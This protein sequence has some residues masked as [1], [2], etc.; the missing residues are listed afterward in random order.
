MFRF[1]DECFFAGRH[2]KIR[3][4]VMSP[5]NA[6]DRPR[7]AAHK[8]PNPHFPALSNSLIAEKQLHSAPVVMHSGP[9]VRLF[10]SCFAFRH[11]MRGSPFSEALSMPSWRP[12]VF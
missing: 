2:A 4:Q 8:S 12:P 9:G 11:L 5:Q 1:T 6:N 3:E 10:A 7:C